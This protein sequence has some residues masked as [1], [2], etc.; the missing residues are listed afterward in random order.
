MGVYIARNGAYHGIPE[1][2]VPKEHKNEFYFHVH[3]VQGDVQVDESQQV[4]RLQG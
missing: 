3:I 2:S 4:R 1:L